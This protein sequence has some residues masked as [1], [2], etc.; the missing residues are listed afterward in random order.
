MLLQDAPT[1]PTP[2]HGAL[3]YV[4]AVNIIIWLGLFGYLVYLD[5]KVRSAAARSRSEMETSR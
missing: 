3:F 4:A 5:L 2:P 1:A